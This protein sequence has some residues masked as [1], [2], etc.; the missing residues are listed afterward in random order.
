M[1]HSLVTRVSVL[2]HLDP[3]DLPSDP[4]VDYFRCVLIVVLLFDLL[5]SQ[6]TQPDTPP[7]TIN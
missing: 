4:R 5:R 1:P 3:P 6:H 2:R 7:T